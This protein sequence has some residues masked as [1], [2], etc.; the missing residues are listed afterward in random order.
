MTKEFFFSNEK[1]DVNEEKQKT[2]QRCNDLKGGNWL[3]YLF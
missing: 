3:F 2:L 1:D